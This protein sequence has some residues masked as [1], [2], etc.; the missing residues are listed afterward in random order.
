MTLAPDSSRTSDATSFSLGDRYTAEA[1]EILVTGI[2][3]LVRLP[4]DQMRA[5]RRAGLR[6]SVFISGYQGSP[7]GGY[8]RELQSQRPLL[9]EYRIVHKP[10]VNEE[11]AAT[12]V[13]GSQ[14]V[15]LLP[16]AKYDGVTG[17]WYGKAPG[18][19][20]AADAIRHAT[21]AGTSRKG[22]VLALAGDDPACKSSTLPSRSDV[23]LAGM[24]LPQ[25]YPGTMQDVLDL[26]RH[27]IEMSRA[28]GQ[29]VA[30]KIVTPV[31]DGT[32]SAIV[33][34]DRVQPIIPIIEINGQPWA[35][36]LS[37]EIVTPYTN[38]IEPEVIGTRME[39]VRQY[40]A[41][42]KLNRIVVDCAK[43]WLGIIAAGYHADQVLEALATLGI[44]ADEAARLG[45]RVL[46][47]AAINPLEQGAVRRL[48]EDVSTV[49]VVE[50]KTPFLETMVRDALYGNTHRPDVIGKLDSDGKPLIPLAGAISASM[51][52]EPLRRVLA[53]KIGADKLAPLRSSEKLR[54]IIPA[55]AVRTPYFCSGCPHNT[56]TVVPEGSLVGAGIGC[57]GMV[58]YMGH[59]SR[60]TI[61]GLTQM[62]GE[63][64]QWVGMEPFIEDQHFFQNIGDGTFFHSGQLAIQMAITS[65][66]NITYKLLYNAA[67][68][69]TG[70]QDAAGLLPVPAVARKLLAEGVRHIIIT[71]DEPDKYRDTSLPSGS[72]VWHRDRIIDAQEKLRGIAGVTV[73]IH[74]QQCAAEKRRDRKRGILPTPEYKLMIDERVCEG[75]GDC[76]VQ[77]NCL[78]L[79]P[80]DT[81]FGRKTMIDQTSCNIDLSEG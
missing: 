21:W 74:D 49:L 32:G 79:Q 64:S 15:Q 4:M 26:G 9:D 75:C 72:E 16:G 44:P 12:A 59:E 6:T 10:G 68:A 70:G 31:A 63:G 52:A 7:L 35:P 51:L 76:G 57:H 48:A 23:M 73:L 45:V 2:Q 54:I 53:R 65:G 71:T 47:L 18:V 80:I 41:E 1:G 69:M 8:D 81:E 67:V 25:L 34:P 13:M 37:G 50:D 20:R 40:I 61:T 56:S 3:A 11:L 30:F 46:K 42:N 27:G 36:S 55:E 62:G 29:W 14:T 22:G 43:P 33:D 17:I 28:A 66:S 5:D 78:S 38:R 77:S 60:G 58:A 19:D 24:G 39:M